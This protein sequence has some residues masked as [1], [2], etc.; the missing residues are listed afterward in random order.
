MKMLLSLTLALLTFFTPIMTT[1]GVGSTPAAAQAPSRSALTIPVTTSVGPGT[2][3]IA[4]FAVQDGQLVARGTVTFLLNNVVQVVPV[5]LPVTAQAI[6]AQADNCPILHL[7]LG[8]LDLNL[9]GLVVHLDKVVLD[10]T[11]QPGPGN[12]LGNLLCAIA[13]LLDPPG[14]LAQLVAA[15]NQLLAVLG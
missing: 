9:L 7:E 12:L 14:P 6:P 8:P 1:I 4:R 13:G 2:L 11:A 10:I 5:V 15:L 3:N